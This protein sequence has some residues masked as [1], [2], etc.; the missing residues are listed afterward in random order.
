MHTP[1]SVFS[2]GDHGTTVNR[3]FLGKGGCGEGGRDFFRRSRV[4]FC[5]FGG[6]A[7]R[8]KGSC[9]FFSKI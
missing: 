2:P 8:S 7:L 9:V 1:M 5:A 3:E 4:R 6:E